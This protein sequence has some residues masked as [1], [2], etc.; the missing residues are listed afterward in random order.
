LDVFSLFNNLATSSQHL[1]AK[2][3]G[4]CSI[5]LVSDS[6]KPSFARASLMA[7]VIAVICRSVMAPSGNFQNGWRTHAALKFMNA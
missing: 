6:V 2:E 1:L 7:D 3:L 5:S 4:P